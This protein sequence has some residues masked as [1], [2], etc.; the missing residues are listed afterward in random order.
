MSHSFRLTCMERS[1]FLKHKMSVVT[2]RFIAPEYNLEDFWE[3]IK[4]FSK[5]LVHFALG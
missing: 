2:W 1:Y 5:T 4:V 3:D